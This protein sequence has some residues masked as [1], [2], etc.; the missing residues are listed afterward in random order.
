MLLFIEL[1]VIAIYF[2]HIELQP[3]PSIVFASS[4]D[5][6]EVIIPSPQTILVQTLSKAASTVHV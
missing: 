5:S 2:W 4:Q 6:V 1:K 3:S